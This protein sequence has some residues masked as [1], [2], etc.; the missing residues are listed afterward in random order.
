VSK[1]ENNERDLLDPAVKGTTEVLKS[2][3]EHNPTVKR[4]VITSSFASI[5]DLSKGARPG[6]TYSEKDWNPVTYETAANPDTNGMVAYLASKTFAEKAAFDFVEK[7]KPNFTISTMCPPMV[8]GPNANT[9]KGL[10]QLNTS[11]ADIYRLINGSEKTVPHTA[12]HRFIDARD[13]GEAHVRAYESPEAAGQRYLLAAGDYTY[14]QICDIIREDFPEKKALV[15]E[16]TPGAPFPNVYHVDNSK[17]KKELGMTFRD[18]R[19][20]I[21]DQVAEFIRIEKAAGKA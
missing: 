4:V 9:I 19:T 5:V 10:D 14:Q 17:A 1:V 15:P 12:F 8:Y 2:V 18:L 6:Y 3:Q 11:S 21:H 13:L 7:N 20:S 16:G